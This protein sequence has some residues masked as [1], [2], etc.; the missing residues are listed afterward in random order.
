MVNEY[1]N[2][3]NNTQLVKSVES[4]QPDIRDSVKI[5]L[6]GFNDILKSRLGLLT[7]NF[8]KSIMR[9]VFFDCFIFIIININSNCF[10]ILN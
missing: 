10:Y 7:D 6:K 4:F 5:A 3:N 2:N 8:N 9:K 1:N